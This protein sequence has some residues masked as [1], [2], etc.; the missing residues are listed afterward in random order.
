[1]CMLGGYDGRQRKKRSS[2]IE[3]G[4]ATFEGRAGARSYPAAAVAVVD[5]VVVVER[6]FRIRDQ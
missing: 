4:R 6:A 1:M 5:V 3:S 2:W